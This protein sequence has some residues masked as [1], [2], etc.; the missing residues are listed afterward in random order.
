[1]PRIIAGR[2]SGVGTGGRRRTSRSR[3]IWIESLGGSL[4]DLAEAQPRLKKRGLR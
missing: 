1:V 3:W 4:D 2:A